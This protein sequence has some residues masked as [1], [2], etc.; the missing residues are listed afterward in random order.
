M[1]ENIKELEEYIDRADSE[2]NAADNSE[3]LR[4][5]QELSEKANYEQE[6]S[7]MQKKMSKMNEENDSLRGKLFDVNE[8][9]EKDTDVKTKSRSLCSSREN[10]DKQMRLTKMD[11]LAELM[12][13]VYETAAIDSMDPEEI[14]ICY[15]DVLKRLGKAINEIRSLKNTVRT[16][17]AASDEMEIAN[18]R[19]NQ[20]LESAEANYTQQMKMLSTK[21]EDLT[22]KYL[23]AE[24]QARLLK[25]KCNEAKSRRR[26]STGIRP[27]EFLINKEAEHV[28]EDIENNLLN[29]EGFVKGKE[30][31]VKEPRK[32][33]YE[34][35]TKASRARRKSSESSELSFVERLKKTDKT[36]SDL[37]RKL[38]LSGESGSVN[39]GSLKKQINAT[40]SKFKSDINVGD[41]GC[42]N[43]SPD[44]L[45]NVLNNLENLITAEDAPMISVDEQP[46]FPQSED[47]SS[48]LDT[49]M[50]FLFQ[51]VEIAYQLR[52]DSSSPAETCAGKI[53]S[54]YDT[55][56]ILAAATDLTS[57]IR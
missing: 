44:D 37:H 35:S 42:N 23:A 27:D 5:R 28:L 47:I 40:I 53:F 14:V 32:K 6:L 48:H 21:I 4:L 55:G 57:A 50:T 56:S 31:L 52:K 34:I 41:G 51:R 13:P 24:K 19:L 16:A 12:N 46:G 43:V 36:I 9:P 22:S 7:E 25:L 15:N 10:I 49:L 33:S 11:S 2:K 38:S 45:E 8:K 39:L 3:I 17:Q 26:S 54:Q 1:K 18:I 30:P 20:S 29:I